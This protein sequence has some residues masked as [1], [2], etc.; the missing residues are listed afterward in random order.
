MAVQFSKIW[1]NGGSRSFWYRL[2]K[3]KEWYKSAAQ[4]QPGFFSK[5]HGV[6][7][8]P[9]LSVVVTISRVPTLWGARWR[10]RRWSCSQHSA[11]LRARSSGCLLL[12]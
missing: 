10:P 3:G 6:D 7:E 9:V 4:E 11:P 8:G 12:V 2:L 1:S 5:C